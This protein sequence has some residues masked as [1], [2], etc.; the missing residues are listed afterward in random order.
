MTLKEII[1]E[2]LRTKNPELDLGNCEIT[3]YEIELQSLNE[4]KHLQKLN[5]ASNQMLN[6]SFLK[7]LIHIKKLY[8]YHSNLQDVSFLESL[9]E[10]EEL[11][12]SG[13]PI[14]DYSYL[15]N[16]KELQYLNLHHNKISDFSFL[17]NL[18]ELQELHLSSTQVKDFT[19]LQNLNQLKYLYLNSNQITNLSFLK[20][21]TQLK[22][23]SLQKNGIQDISSLD[24]LPQL[25]RLDL[26]YNEIENISLEFLNKFVNLEELTV[27]GNPIKNIPES[28]YRSTNGSRYIFKNIRNYLEDQEKSSSSDKTLKIIL[29][30]NGS[31]GKTQI[32][33]RWTEGKNYVFESEHNSTHAIAFL[34]KKLGD[35]TLQ[36][37]DFCRT[38]PLPC[39][40]SAFYE[41]Q[42]HFLLGLGF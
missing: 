14:Q 28:L 34:E 33:K 6:T 17:Q 42:C 3:G 7:G 39:H 36:L 31:V 40:A 37:W 18:V 19:F 12:L 5:L 13:N 21:A 30:G 16:L 25:K 22:S 24:S 9:P 4:Y 1:E 29:I 2:N 8:L 41:N 35:V 11:V 10:L 32:A 27:Y 20:D 38:R 15:K 26:R 23:L